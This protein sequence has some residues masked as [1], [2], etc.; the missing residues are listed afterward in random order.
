LQTADADDV[1]QEVF[2]AVARA[3][4]RFRKDRP[5]D[6]FRG[7]LRTITRSK[8][9]DHRRRR[10]SEPQATGGSDAHLWFQ[11]LAESL[12]GDGD[13][14]GESQEVAKLRHRA[15]EMVR[16][17]F[18]ERTWQAFWRV[19]VEGQAVKDVAADLSVTP[20]AVRL[21]KSRVLR[22]LREELRDLEP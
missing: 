17:E 6:T 3:I 5:H 10:C 18:E 8:L 20:S 16:A 14:V 1:F 9:I 7:W 11:E 2:H 15:L 22:R 4:G 19:T 21:A 13:D 12:P